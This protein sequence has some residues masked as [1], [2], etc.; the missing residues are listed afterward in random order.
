MQVN[1]VNQV[2]ITIT[3]TKPIWFGERKVLPG[4]EAIVEESQIDRR[5]H[6]IKILGKVTKPTRKRRVK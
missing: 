4:Q 5:N 3:G 2:K 6:R 1:Q